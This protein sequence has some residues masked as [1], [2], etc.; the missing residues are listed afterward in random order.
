LKIPCIEIYSGLFEITSKI[1]RA[2]TSLSLPQKSLKKLA[3][4]NLKILSIKTI[5]SYFWN[6]VIE[7]MALILARKIKIG[8]RSHPDSCTS[9]SPQL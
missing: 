2:R 6:L 8:K 1:A 3:L 5:A 4:I 9:R 7:K